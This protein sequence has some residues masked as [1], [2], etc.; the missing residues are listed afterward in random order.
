MSEVERAVGGGA[1]RKEQ[2]SS[3]QM[4][5]LLY[6]LDHTDAEF[7][8]GDDADGLTE[9]EDLV[10][11]GFMEEQRIGTH[12]LFRPAVGLQQKLSAFL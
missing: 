1:L 5:L 3:R 2:L 10:R 7:S 11:R 12:L 9:L 6:A 4:G 8:K